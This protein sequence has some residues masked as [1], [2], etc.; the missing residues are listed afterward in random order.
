MRVC[1]TYHGPMR[2]LVALRVAAEFSIVQRGHIPCS[3]SLTEPQNGQTNFPRR[4]S[5]M[6]SASAPL[7]NVLA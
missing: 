7:D 3:L 5:R 6:V 4:P 1:K 2:V